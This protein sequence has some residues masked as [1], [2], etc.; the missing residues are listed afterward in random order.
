M[1]RREHGAKTGRDWEMLL[2]GEGQ[3]RL[4]ATTRKRQGAAPPQ[5]LQE[6]P[7]D[8]FIS[9]LWPPY[10]LENE[11]LFIQAIHFLIICSAA[12][13]NEYRGRGYF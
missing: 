9:D 4:S 3:R 2:Q 11:V 8:R 13:R 12:L 10:L 6:N 1:K 5:S 7:I